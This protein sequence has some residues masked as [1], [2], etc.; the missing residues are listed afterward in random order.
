MVVAFLICGKLALIALLCQIAIIDFTEQKIRNA[1]LLLVLALAAAIL[2]AAWLHGADPVHIGMTLASALIMFVL[3][4]PFWAFGKV[5]A[6]D[7]KYLAMAPLIAS[8]ENLIH[9]AI[10]LLIAA[11]ITALVIRNPILLPQGLFRQYIQH[12][13]RKRVVPFGVPISAALIVVLV[14]QLISIVSEIARTSPH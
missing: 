4:F 14:L 5:G 13:E 9:F 1:D 6:G 3:L 10:A 8:G 2:F 11:A 7:V 12:L